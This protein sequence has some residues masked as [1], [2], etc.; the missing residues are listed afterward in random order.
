MTGLRL[1]TADPDD[2]EEPAGIV[3]TL[4]RLAQNTYRVSWETL[5]SDDLHRT[6]GILVFGVRRAVAAGARL[7]VP[8]P[9]RGGRAALAGAGRHRPGPRRRAD[10][11]AGAAPAR[12]RPRR[13]GRPPRRACPWPVRSV[14][15]LA[16]VVLLG[17]QL[18]PGGL[19]LGDLLAAPTACAGSCGRRA[20]SR[21]SCPPW[22]CG[23]PAR[24]RSPPCWWPGRSR[25]APG[26][27]LLGHAGAGPSLDL[28]R[29]LATTAHLLAATTWAGALACLALLLRAPGLATGAGHRGAARAAAVLRAPGGGVRHGDG[30]DGG[31][32]SPP[33]WSARSTRHCARSTG[34][35]CW[36]SWRWSPAP[37][38]WRSRTTGRCAAG[39]T[40][41]PRAV[42]SAAEAALA[43]A[44]VAVTAVLT[45]GQPATEPALVRDDVVATPGPVAGQVQDLE[46]SVSLRPNR[47]GRNVAVVDVF[48]SRRPAPA[49]I[50]GVDVGIGTSTPVPATALEDG[51]WTSRAV[52]AATGA[53]S[54][55]VVVHRAGVPDVTSR[56]PL[57]RRR[58]TGPDPSGAG[59]HGP[60]PVRAAAPRGTPRC[61][62][63]CP[64]GSGAARPA[65][66]SHGARGRGRSPLPRAPEPVPS[67]AEDRR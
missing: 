48:D 17:V 42:P 49:P 27:A 63:G 57:D 39:T 14:A 21:W 37:G 31:A 33:T 11:P 5:S 55:T 54:I 28:T 9:A 25:R 56:D 61:R 22:P 40:W 1:V 52:D 50:L 7:G 46:Q 24:A 66:P 65:A 36:S 32:T 60:G 19:G 30:G 44:V 34:A 43:L 3:A 4:P 15:A 18:A 23:V 13:D 45:S 26:T 41:T 51:H 58:G 35:P 38:C 29:V 12:G 6:S 16:A 10:P 47:P 64:L 20:C 2:T 59:V 62:G 8:A 53:T 67:R